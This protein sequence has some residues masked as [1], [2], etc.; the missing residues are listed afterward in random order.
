MNRPPLTAGLVVAGVWLATVAL[1]PA[2]GAPSG[3]EV[4][5]DPEDD[6][7]S[8]VRPVRPRVRPPAR[9][10]TRRQAVAAAEEVIADPEDDLRAAPRAR[11]RA[12]KVAAAPSFVPRILVGGFLQ[13]WAGFDVRHEGR[14]RDLP[15]D[16][17][18]SED[19]FELYTRARLNVTSRFK[20]WV[21]V[22]LEARLTHWVSCER[23]KGKQVLWL[24]N[25]EA[26][27]SRAEVELGEAY[28]DLYL[29]PV[30]L[31]LGQQIVS[32]GLSDLINPND[33]VNPRD[34]RQGLLAFDD[35]LRRPVLALR[36]SYHLR[37]LKVE[38]VWLPLFKS[39]R[40]D[41]YGS[42]FALLGP[43]ASSRLAQAEHQVER[44]LDPTLHPLAQPLFLQTQRPAD[45]L[46]AST[47][48][49]RVAASHRGW[50]VA[51]QYF[52]GWD[53]SPSLSVDGQIYGLAMEGRLFVDDT[54]NLAALLPL[55]EGRP[56][57]RS[58]FEHTHQVGLSVGKAFEHVAVKLDVSYQPDRGFIRTDPVASPYGSDMLSLRVEHHTL[59]SAL[60]V[61]YAWGG[62]LVAQLQGVH[63]A[64]L[65]R[66]P[67]DTRE[68]MGF[69]AEPHAA[70]LVALLRL[71]LLRQTLLI[72]A[73]AAVDL[74]HGS[75]TL[76]PM[77]HYK[78]T[79]HWRVG[80]GA[81]VFEG[82]SDTLFG[83]WTK[84]DLVWA[85]L[86]WSF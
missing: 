83:V 59:L 30:D 72:T 29:G 68:L 80:V 40:M 22:H 7:R 27:R 73:A 49:L 63:L 33:V 8:R 17:R 78:I 31:R 32:W 26:W 65:D 84:N 35:D 60:S 79:D 6:L 21:K 5:V 28:V 13:L 11:P 54:I 41:L 46:T 19:V 18:A 9:K 10:I 86:R 76:A 24:G 85:D 38:A 56:L 69:L 23:P 2:K 74:L 53:L 62:K 77:V 71:Q 45:D 14:R 34:L 39:H 67:G 64:L 70:L 51:L 48:G 3:D 37:W 47:A 12:R 75:V 16:L 4:I 58:T 15:D 57:Y 61:E 42:D 43:G 82:A 44:L 36:A 25:G 20:R 66:R 81:L 50:D 1:C 55:M 52:F